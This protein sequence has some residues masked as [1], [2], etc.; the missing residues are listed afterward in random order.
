MA[1]PIMFV[2]SLSNKKIFNQISDWSKLKAFTEALNAGYQHLLFHNL[3]K[4]F[5]FRVFKRD[6]CG[7]KLWLVG[8]I[9]VYA[10]LRAR[11]ISTWLVM[12]LFP[13][14]LTPVLT[15]LSFQRPLTTFLS[16]SYASAEVRSENTLERKFATGYQTHKHQ[17]MSLTTEPPWCG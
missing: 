13:G 17:V 8:C 2:H 6:M 5:L 1:D 16:L 9:G 7:K 11:V 15:Q 10:T 12:H 3:F 4:S 14:F